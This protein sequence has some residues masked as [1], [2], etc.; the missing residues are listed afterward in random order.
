MACTVSTHANRTVIAG[1]C[2]TNDCL[3]VQTSAARSTT[4]T[5]GSART[6]T[7]A[8]PPRPRSMAG[9]PPSSRSSPHG[10][11]HH[12]RRLALVLRCHRQPM[13][14][15]IRRLGRRRQRAQLLGSD[16]RDDSRPWRR[17]HPLQGARP[18]RPS[19]DAYG[20]GR[21]QREVGERGLFQ[22]NLRPLH[23]GNKAQRAE[24]SQLLCQPLV[25]HPTNGIRSVL[26]SNFSLTTDDGVFR[27]GQFHRIERRV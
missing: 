3:H 7:A 15:G 22:L 12:A 24:L 18:G 27:T 11:R 25:R 21:W 2:L 5:T 20:Q 23:A 6:P 9:R 26:F 19:V 17:R 16:R 10:R 4:R 14:P 1:T 13:P 8:A